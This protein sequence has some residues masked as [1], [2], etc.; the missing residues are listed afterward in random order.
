MN[1]YFIR[2]TVH[3]MIYTNCLAF[4]GNSTSF[5]TVEFTYI[6]IYLQ[7]KK[8]SGRPRTM[9]LD[10]LLKTEED[11]IS[12]DELKMLAQDRSRWCQ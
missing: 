3:C 8:G 4:M 5:K 9:F 2:I 6:I 7:G 11:K 1:T 10:W 12:F